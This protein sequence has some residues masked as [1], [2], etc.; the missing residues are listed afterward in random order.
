MIFIL[1]G[2]LFTPVESMPAW[3]QVI[4]KLNPVTYF[5]E[6][7][8]MVVIKGSGFW[9]ILPHLGAVILFAIFF[10]AWAVLNYRKTS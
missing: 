3:A 2:G 4:S 6:V 5:I 9:N 8:R 1:M 10:N 7:M